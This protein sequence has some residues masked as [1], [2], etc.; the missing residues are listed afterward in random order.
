MNK[1]RIII[2]GVTGS[3]G[4]S[5]LSV[6]KN[7]SARGWDFEVTGMSCRSNT[8]L[9]LSSAADFGV[10]N[11][12]ATAPEKGIPEIK[13]TGEDAVLRLLKETECDIVVNGIAGSSGLEPSI[14]ALELGRDLA[15]ANKET[16]VMAWPQAS[17]LADRNGSAI[18]PVDSEHSA[19]FHLLE[20]RDR[21]T[22]RRLIITASGG[23]F[24]TTPLEDFP[25]LTLKDALKHPTWDMG[26]KITVD[27]ATMANK[28]LEV[29]E[30]H[31]LFNMPPENISVTIHP[32]SCV[33][34]LV[35]TIDGSL[36]AQVSAPDMCIPIQN[37]LTYPETWESPFGK[38]SFE[39]LHLTFSTPD[40][41]R[42]PMLP[43][44]YETIKT[45]GIMPIVYNAANEAAVESFSRG[46]IPFTAIAE[47]VEAALNGNWTGSPENVEEIMEIHR[48][49]EKRALAIV[50]RR[51][52]T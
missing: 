41:R 26:A 36:Y 1:K 12:A 43:L 33:H 22:L 44:A 7:L 32:Q 38:L 29:I 37:A 48:T 49:A 34:S 5:T 46:E 25:S 19:L 14:K 9:L 24:R 31:R 17:K 21:E 47:V 30:A 35:E 28:G 2:L 45:E 42:Y 6:L 20:G 10:S 4:R 50:S 3:I 11:L 51:K 8:E 18:I 13:W 16:V 23:A 52:V 27:S 39:D 40:Y 15:L